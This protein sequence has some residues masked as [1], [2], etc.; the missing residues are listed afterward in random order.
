[1]ASRI[2]TFRDLIVWQTSMDLSVAI[3]R[4]T[5]TFP[6]EEKY[7][8]TNQ[9]RR[10]SVSVPSNIAEGFGRGTRKDYRQ[11]LVVSRGSALEL[12]TQLTLARRLGFGRL[13]ELEQA[14]SLADEVVRMLYGIVLKL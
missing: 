7:G 5:G 8:L 13:V 6:P 3:Y 14:E 11:F 2:E 4:L 9:L 12:Q 1:M 10:A